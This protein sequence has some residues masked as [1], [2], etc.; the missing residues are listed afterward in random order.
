MK[1]RHPTLRYM[2]GFLLLFAWSAPAFGHDHWINNR[3]YKS[4]KGQ[5]CCD[6]RS[7]NGDCD[8]INPSAVKPTADGQG[9]MTPTGR[10]GIR[11]TYFSED[12]KTYLCSPPGGP[13][14]CLFIPG[15]G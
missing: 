5:H 15:G 1:A 14:R 9:Y 8:E 3:N 6:H 10:V 11:S 12:G 2:A 13:P 7:K 4:E